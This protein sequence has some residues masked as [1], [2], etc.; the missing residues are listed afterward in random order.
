MDPHSETLGALKS[1]V[2][3]LPPIDLKEGETTGRDNEGKEG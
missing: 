3:T 2:P 1:D